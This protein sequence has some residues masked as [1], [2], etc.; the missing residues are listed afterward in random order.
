MKIPLTTKI[1]SNYREYLQASRD[2]PKAGLEPTASA[3]R[4]HCSTN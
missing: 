1:I 3:L 2:M 4:M